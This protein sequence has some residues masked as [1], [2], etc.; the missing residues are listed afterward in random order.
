V[1]FPRIGAKAPSL[2]LEG[3]LIADAQPAATVPPIESLAPATVPSASTATRYHKVG[4]GDTLWGIAER[5]LGAGHR[6]QELL[7]ANPGI[8]PVRLIPGQ[9]LQLPQAASPPP[10]TLTELPASTAKPHH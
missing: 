8:D 2:S 4:R 9:R 7:Q 3:A 5:T 10:R 1:E 6:Y